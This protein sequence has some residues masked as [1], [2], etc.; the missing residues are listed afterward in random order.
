MLTFIFGLI[1]NEK[2]HFNSNITYNK[3]SSIGKGCYY[4]I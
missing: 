1:I 4:K 3:I 2:L